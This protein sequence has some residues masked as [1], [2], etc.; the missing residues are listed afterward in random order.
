MGKFISL[1]YDFTFKELF[2]NETVRKHFISDVLGIPLEEIRSVRLANTFLW[3]RYVKQKQGILD[4]LMILNDD[5][6]VNIELQIKMYDRW[7]RR[8]LFYLAKIF[9]ED[10]LIGEQYR[11]LRKCIGI[12]ILNFNLDNDPEYHKVYRLRDESGREFS[13]RL[14][15]HIIELNKKLRGTEQMDDWIRLFKAETEEELDMIRTQ[16]RNPGVL[17][18]IKEVKVM[19][20]GKNLRALY[21]AYMMEKR[22]KAAW[23]YTLREQ[24]EEKLN[25]LIL[26]LMTDKRYEDLEKAARDKEYRAQLYKEYQL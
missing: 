10:I 22:D 21:E 25:Q 3:R 7:D 12:N 14:E 9:T 11:K 16:T 8:S 23:E 18:A 2:T 19:N 13:D 4:V 6:K 17:E 24:G 5:S 1:K 15:I 20:L 26:K